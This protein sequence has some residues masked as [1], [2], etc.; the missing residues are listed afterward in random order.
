[1]SLLLADHSNLKGEKKTAF[2]ISDH[3]DSQQI[4]LMNSV[5]HL[6]SLSKRYVVMNA[7]STIG[8]INSL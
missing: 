8:Y 6:V 5:A 2:L 7:I 1:M 3:D 4:L